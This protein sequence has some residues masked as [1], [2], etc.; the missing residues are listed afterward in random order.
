MVPSHG[1]GSPCQYVAFQ[2]F[3]AV[4]FLTFLQWMCH[5]RNS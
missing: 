4:N 1:S 3:A 2:L 5:Y